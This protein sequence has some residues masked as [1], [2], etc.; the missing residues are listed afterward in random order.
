MPDWKRVSQ[1]HEQASRMTQ[2]G[3]KKAS[4]RLL[5]LDDAL[6]RLGPIVCRHHGTGTPTLAA[7]PS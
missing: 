4:R 1:T 3:R 2:Q 7:D 5:I 6:V